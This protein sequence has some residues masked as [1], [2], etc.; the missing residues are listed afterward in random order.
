MP[1]AVSLAAS[2]S[3]LPSG[4]CMPGLRRMV[5]RG[6]PTCGGGAG[7]AHHGTGRSKVQ[8]LSGSQGSPAR[9][10]LEAAP[11]LSASASVFYTVRRRWVPPFRRP[12]PSRAR[13]CARMRPRARARARAGAIHTTIN[14][15][16][17]GLLL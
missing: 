15:N 2:R 4:R 10:R 5:L 11:A 9:R 8:I 14:V 6:G 13:M 12:L 1:A 17:Y 7:L 3:N 16:F